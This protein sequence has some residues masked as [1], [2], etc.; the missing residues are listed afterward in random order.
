MMGRWED[1]KM[2]RWDGFAGSFLRCDVRYSV[3]P[4]KRTAGP[5]NMICLGR[6]ISDFN[7]VFV[8]FFWCPAL[9]FFWGGSNFKF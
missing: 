2:G 5:L 7:D 1:G 4:R 6:G 3:F 9:S 8:D